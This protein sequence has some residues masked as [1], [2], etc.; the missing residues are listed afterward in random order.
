MTGYHE[1]H[2]PHLCSG[3]AAF[4]V[5][6]GEL[7]PSSHSAIALASSLCGDLHPSLLHGGS[8][9]PVLLQPMWGGGGLYYTSNFI[10]NK[11]CQKTGL[12]R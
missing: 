8:V 10:H 2:G 4:V 12:S 1:K 9:L 7:L 11:C 5:V 6:V 3:V